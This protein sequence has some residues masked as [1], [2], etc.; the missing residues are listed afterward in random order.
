MVNHSNFGC[1]FALGVVLGGVVVPTGV[2]VAVAVVVEAA[3]VEVEVDAAAV[4]VA[5]AEV[6]VAKLDMSE[7]CVVDC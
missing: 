6:L 1:F 5:S 2:P 7:I 3:E 4:E